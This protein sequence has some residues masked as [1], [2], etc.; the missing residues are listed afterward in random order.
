VMPAVEP[1]PPFVPAVVPP[2]RARLTPDL[3]AL[4]LDPAAKERPVRVIVLFAEPVDD[5]VEDLRSRI[6][7]AFGPSAKRN[8][9]G[10]VV[11]GPDGLAALTEGA[12]L[13]GAVGNLAAIRFDRPA[14]AERY[15]AEPGVLSVR[16]PRQATETIAPRPA[17]VKS[18]PAADVSK[19]FG[20]EAL[21]RLGYTGGGVK[22]VLVASDFSGAEKLIGTVF[23]KNTRILDLTTELNADI[24][25]SPPDPNRAG[26]GTAAARAFVLAAPDAELVLVRIDPGAIFQLHG[27]LRLARGDAVYSEAMRS[28][29]NDI[30]TKSADLTR[31]KEAAITEYREAFA[32]LGD[33]DGTRARR[34][35]A[36]AALDAVNAEQD[37]LVK[38]IQRFNTFHKEA[39]AALAEARVVVNTLEWESGYPLDALSLLSQT[40]EQLAAPPP[41]R[42]V[43][44]PTDPATL[45]KPPIVWVQA[46]S[47]SGAAVWGGPFL[48][49]NRNG[50]MEFAPPTQPLPPSNWSPEMNFLGVQS[51]AG[52]LTADLPAG[53]KVRFTMQWREPLDPNFPDPERPVHPVVLRVFRQLDPNGTTRPS[54]EMAEDAR[55]SAGPYPILL[56][57]TFV[58]YEQILDFTV[59]SAGRYALVAATG[60]QPDPL[61]PALRREAEIHPRLFVETLSAK[62]GEAQVVFRSYVNP[63]AG[64][65][66]PG[67]SNGVATIGAPLPGQLF[68]GGTG[69]T[70]RAKPDL[71]G[72][73]TLDAD[74]L[75]SRGTGVATAYVG[76]IAA[77]LVQA[78]A[79][80]P[81]VFRSTGI[82]PGQ[83]AVVPE[84][85]LRHLKP[86]LK[87]QK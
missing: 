63:R 38:R 52:E 2:A 72:P 31:R 32:D 79:A 5:R 70:L 34:A 48:D 22:V 10:T 74:G 75:A 69:I 85:W 78:G 26:T 54:D 14:D 40:L 23:P 37:Q 73:D 45:P 44:R 67:D 59:P 16:L 9:D 61:L 3:R 57:K 4:L 43:R 82:A 86:I 19:A 47:A 80:G 17:G 66:I 58:V 24:V 76:G 41:P 65:G 36:K 8:A 46:A 25:P 53:A 27:I 50:T 15:A 87:P 6:A 49:A 11:K 68:G 77:G 83:W 81:N 20:V 84:T 51:P 30:A 7:A 12:A 13:D 18:A 64:V 60:Y 56:T 62:P 39:V 28:R 71:F 33:D 35:K 55:S 29:L 42:T 1:P 21:H